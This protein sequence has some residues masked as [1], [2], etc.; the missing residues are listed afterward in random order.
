LVKI[1][2]FPEPPAPGTLSHKRY[3]F[4]KEMS[5]LLDKQDE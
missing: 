4:V 1:Q 3:T 2:I 5:E